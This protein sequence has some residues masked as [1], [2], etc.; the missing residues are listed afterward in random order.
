MVTLLYH[1]R[2]I[3]YICK[4][5]ASESEGKIQVA[6]DRLE[7]PERFEGAVIRWD[8][9]A[10]AEADKTFN[11]WE[12]VKLSRNKALSRLKMEGLCPPTWN[13][14]DALS[15]PCIMRPRRHFAAKKFF[16][17]KD[18]TSA[19]KAA[20]ACRKGWYASPIVDKKLE[21]RVFV[22][23]GYALKVV[24]R[25]HPQQEQVAWNIANGGVSTRLLRESWPIP[26]VQ[27]A[28][29]AGDKLGLE[30]YAADV[31]VDKDEKPYVLE[32]NTAPGLQR[33]QTLKTLVKVFTSKTKK[34]EGALGSTWKSLIHPS[35]T[36]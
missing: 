8:S 32:L 5:I 22:F 15:Y 35:L 29:T 10:P 12:A 30:W 19:R 9:R 13:T 34:R 3:G 24:R 14:L 25:H 6:S 26:A 17:C 20:K 11:T 21:Y 1:A 33:P 7:L 4:R 23:N 2:T 28:I 27:A 36:R 16:I 18:R 31:I